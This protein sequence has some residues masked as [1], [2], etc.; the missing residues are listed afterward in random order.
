MTVDVKEPAGIFSVAV[1]KPLWPS[2]EIRIFTSLGR[3][4]QHAGMR[5][6]G[7]RF[8]DSISHRK[9]RCTEEAGKV[10]AMTGRKGFR[11]IERG[12]CRDAVQPA[13]CCAEPDSG[14]GGGLRSRVGPQPEVQILRGRF[15]RMLERRKQ[16]AWSD[17]N[18]DPMDRRERE[19]L[20]L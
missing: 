17:R 19:D 7:H 10:L 14:K 6:G 5:M 13:G 12:R 11:L 9:T 18:N 2:D 8:G 16:G 3:A 15:P 1:N 4:K 20:T